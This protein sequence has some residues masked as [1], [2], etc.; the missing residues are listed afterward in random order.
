[1]RILHIFSFLI[2]SF[3]N[4]GKEVSQKTNGLRSLSTD[5]L[6]SLKRDAFSTLK[7][8][9]MDSVACKFN[10]DNL[11]CSDKNCCFLVILKEKATPNNAELQIVLFGIFR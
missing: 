9:S 2:F 10:G 5:Q 4:G 7:R 6:S 8:E 1:M 3:P 11:L